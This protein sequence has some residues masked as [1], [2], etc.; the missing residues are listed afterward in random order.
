MPANQVSEQHQLLA[1]HYEKSEHW[2][3]AFTHIRVA[4]EEEAKD[5]AVQEA[6]R[7]YEH[8]L[9]L[10]ERDGSDVTGDYIISVL[11]RLAELMFAQGQFADSFDIVSRM[12]KLARETGDTTAEGN[13]AGQHGDRQHVAGRF[14]YRT[15]TR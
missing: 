11:Q 1:Y 15:R 4:A 3:D 8:A 12:H 6:S 13:R 2:S 7:L 10:G 14:R 5:Y 9:R